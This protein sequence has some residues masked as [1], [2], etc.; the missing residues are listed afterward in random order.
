MNECWRTDEGLVEAGVVVETVRTI[1]T[2][3]LSARFNSFGSG[4]INPF[5]RFVVSGSGD[6]ANVE[7]LTQQLT[8]LGRDQHLEDAKRWMEGNFSCSRAP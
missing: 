1:D 4:V 7:L 8:W 2:I 5:V 6:R 3:E